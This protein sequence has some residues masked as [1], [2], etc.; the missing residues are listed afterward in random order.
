MHAADESEGAVA[1]GAA[2]REMAA[3]YCINGS[4]EVSAA[5]FS[6]LG[7]RGTRTRRRERCTAAV[8]IRDR[9]SVIRDSPLLIRDKA[10]PR[11]RRA[12]EKNRGNGGDAPRRRRAIWPVK[13]ALCARRQ[14]T[15]APECLV[16]DLIRRGLGA[17]PS[18]TDGQLRDHASSFEPY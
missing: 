15:S 10:I 6:C 9:P 1:N 16:F 12:E 14:P 7:W 5:R 4:V 11:R 8:R 13:R 3:A 18:S 17:A 2:E